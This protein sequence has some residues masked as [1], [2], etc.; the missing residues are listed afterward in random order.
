MRDGIKDGVKRNQ[1]VPRLIDVFRVGD[2]SEVDN[3]NDLLGLPTTVR[4]WTLNVENTK[5]TLSGVLD[6]YNYTLPNQGDVI[7]H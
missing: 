2:C 6:V 1:V 5:R 3:E 7:V 4:T